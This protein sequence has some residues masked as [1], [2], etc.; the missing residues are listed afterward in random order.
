[1]G[2]PAD[3]IDDLE[4]RIKMYNSFKLD[5]MSPVEAAKSV[6]IPTFLYHVHD[7]VMTRPSDI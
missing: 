2:I 6:K 3:W 7:N 1:M 5:D 4:E